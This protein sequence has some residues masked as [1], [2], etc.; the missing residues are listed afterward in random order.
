MNLSISFIDSV[1]SEKVSPYLVGTSESFRRSIEGPIPPNAVCGFNVRRFRSLRERKALALLSW[2]LGDLGVLLRLDLDDWSSSWTS[3]ER[4]EVSL[5]C[6]SKTLALSALQRDHSERDFFGN[7]L[8]LLEKCAKKL[9]YLIRVPASPKNP[10]RRR[11][12]RDHGTLRPET[13]WLPKSD[14]S[15]TELQNRL[16]LSRRREIHLLRTSCVQ[17][18]W[19][20][21]KLYPV[22]TIQEEKTKT[23][24]IL[25]SGVVNKN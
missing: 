6:Q 16:E 9:R 21:F 24:V 22:K 19:K 13:Q 15:L 1:L 14:Y 2:Y 4:L 20:T 8:V 3:K 23:L 18:I 11:G 17:L 7:S 10:V 12:Y 5:L 25:P